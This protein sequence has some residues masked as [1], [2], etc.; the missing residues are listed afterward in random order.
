MYTDHKPLEVIYKPT[1]KPPARIE[2]WALRLQPY[3]FK[4][5]YSPG[6]HNPADV[7][8]RLPLTDQP[9]NHRIVQWNGVECSGME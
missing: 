6:A 7:L 4:V 1:S 8:S 3:R 2:R 9:H 5:I